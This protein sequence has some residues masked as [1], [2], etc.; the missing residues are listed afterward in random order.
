[1]AAAS[2]PA[3]LP[4]KKAASPMK[5]NGLNTLSV[6]G[7]HTK[8]SNK[9]ADSPSLNQQLPGSSSVEIQL[10][11]QM[12]SPTMSR[13]QRLQQRGAEL[14][15]PPA[16]VSH[17]QILANLLEQVQPVDFRAL[18]GLTDDRDKLHTPHYV[19]IVVEQV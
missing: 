14:A 1:M 6:L 4:I 16:A 11:S 2:M 17:E 12:G 10:E 18:A 13:T 19:V 9:A 5:A 8:D 3:V 15:A 7:E